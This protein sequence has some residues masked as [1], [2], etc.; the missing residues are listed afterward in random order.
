MHATTA[1]SKARAIH[2]DTQAAMVRIA[3]TWT[4]GAHAL[5]QGRAHAYR[6]PSRIIRAARATLEAIPTI[7]AWAIIGAGAFPAIGFGLAMVSPTGSAGQ[8][9][10]ARMFTLTHDALVF[11]SSAVAGAV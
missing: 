3:P 11:V 9:I 4:I 1:R 8:R 7:C 10:A 6:K 5:K 2:D